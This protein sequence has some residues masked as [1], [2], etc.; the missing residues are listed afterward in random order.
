[1]ASALFLRSQHVSDEVCVYSSVSWVCVCG[2]RQSQV[3]YSVAPDATRT[4]PTTTTQTRAAAA[5]STPADYSPLVLPLLLLLPLVLLLLRTP[6]P[7]LLL[8]AECSQL[9]LPLPL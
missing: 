7:L 6:P 4:G 9:L 3:P 1:M 5:L 8:L 2:L